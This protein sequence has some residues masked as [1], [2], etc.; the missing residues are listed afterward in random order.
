MTRPHSPFRRRIAGA[1]AS[2][3]VALALA[4]CQGASEPSGPSSPTAPSTDRTYSNDE[5]T[6]ALP[7]PTELSDLLSTEPTHESPP[8]GR[9]EP[10]PCADLFFAGA[11]E[12]AFIDA[13]T[14]GLAR[15]DYSGSRGGMM[16]L[17]VRSFDQP[18]PAEWF[19]RAGTAVAECTSFTKI[20]PNRT[21]TWETKLLGTDPLGDRSFSVRLVGGADVDPGGEASEVDLVRAGK[22]HT[23]IL[24][25]YAVG[26]ASERI[27]DLAERAVIQVLNGLQRADS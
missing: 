8:A 5:L 10:A 3:I 9:T 6:A 12:R 24:V 22:G 1:A 7:E 26:P 23:L 19:D 20:D 15:R 14:V 21:S 25:N 27:P 16:G 17:T 2:A 4:A 18:V 13:H 11:D